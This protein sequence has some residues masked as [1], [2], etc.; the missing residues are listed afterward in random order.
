M[1]R[2]DACDAC[3]EAAGCFD[4]LGC[5]NPESQGLASYEDITPA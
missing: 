5:L 2:S 3:G 4:L 1:S